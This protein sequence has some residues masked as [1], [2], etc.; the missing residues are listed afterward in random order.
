[1]KKII[2]FFLI[3]LF[4]INFSK[5]YSNEKIFIEIRVN[6]EIITN[7]DIKKEISYLKLLN[8]NLNN[9]KKSQISKIAKKSLVNET[10]KKNELKKIF[11]YDKEISIINEIYKDFY[12]NLKF[13][14]ETEFKN[15]LSTSTNYSTSEI[16]E[17]LKTEFFWNRL[18][19]DKFNKQ[20]KIDEEKLK[21]KINKFE[22]KFKKQYFLSEIFFKIDKNTTVEKR[23]SKIKRSINKEGF[24]NTA[25]IF[26]ISE[27]A[28]YGGKIGWVD[29]ESLSKKVLDELKKIKIGEF[30]R[31]IKVN[32][33]YIILK[34][35]DLKLIEI[36][37]DKKNLLQRMIDFERNKQLNQYSKI[38]FNKVKI[39]YSINEK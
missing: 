28:K 23:I 36:K 35:D 1:M 34:I 29:E 39:N 21:I 37:N 16:K 3:S 18:I 24:R 26:S 19:L 13:S 9:I 25:N 8:P 32:N 2:Y 38:Y 10:I 33:N 31:A 14:N 20:V 22:K 30:T 27:T 17:K 4:L 12:S 7:I 5:S 15:K 6:N 11:N